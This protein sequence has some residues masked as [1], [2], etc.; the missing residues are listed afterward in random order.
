MTPDEINLAIAEWR[1]WKLCSA[2]VKGGG[3]HSWWEHPDVQYCRRRPDYYHDLNAITEAVESLGI[4]AEEWAH[5]LWMINCWNRPI[6]D[7]K[8]ML[9]LTNATAPQR[10]EAL[11]RT[12]NL[13]KGE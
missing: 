13:W 7:R 2:P 8:A 10:C 11:L 4:D 12:I 1:G 6:S 5:R 9:L 3:L